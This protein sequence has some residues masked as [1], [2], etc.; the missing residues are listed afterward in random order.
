MKARVST[1]VVLLLAGCTPAA[2][3]NRKAVASRETAASEA[4]IVAREKAAQAWA[5]GDGIVTDAEYRGAADKYIG[6]MADAGYSATKPVVSPIDGLTLLFDI[7]PF[8]DPA[9]YNEKLDYCNGQHFS[10]IEP[11]FVEARKQVM[12]A[13]LREATVACLR[14]KG[15]KPTGAESSVGEFRKTADDSVDA[16]MAC[17]M[18]AAAALYPELPETLKIRS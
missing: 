2:D 6:C 16:A 3:P 15:F 17:V 18:S 5:L 10:W 4:A 7:E 9:V 14:D 12:A 13:P 11:T 1:L 8:G